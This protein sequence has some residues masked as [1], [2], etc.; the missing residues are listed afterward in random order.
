MPVRP[1]VRYPDPVLKALAEEVA[2]GPEAAELC[3]DL[4]DTMQAG[5]ACVGLAAPQIGVGARAFCLDVSAHKKARSTHGLIVMLNPVIVGRK[6]RNVMREGCMSLPD[7]TANVA[8]AE[9]IIVMGFDLEERPMLIEAD[10]FEA[11]AFQHE[12][13]HCYGTLFLDRVASLAS[14][15]FPRKRYAR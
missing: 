5:P 13:D 9:E 6:G 4:V 11:R 15:V 2:P 3:R 8:R 12:I 1:I 7:F 14:D 10:G